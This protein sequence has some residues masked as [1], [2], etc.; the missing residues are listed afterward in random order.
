[1]RLPSITIP[2]PVTSAGACLVQGLKKSG[3]RAVEKTFTTEFST[4]LV[5]ASEE[6][7]TGLAALSFV[8]PDPSAATH[9]GNSE[10]KT[11][12]HNSSPATKPRTGEQDLMPHVKQP[13][14]ESND[15]CGSEAAPSASRY[16]HLSA[17]RPGSQ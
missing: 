10:T 2:V 14:I 17:S 9:R 16:Y 7:L 1:M 6:A 12:G 8:P 5:L 11:V 4:R 13:T 3:Y 15:G